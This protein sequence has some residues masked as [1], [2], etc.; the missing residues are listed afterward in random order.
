MRARTGNAHDYHRMSRMHFSPNRLLRVVLFIVIALAL[1]PAPIR[2][3]GPFEELFGGKK[4]QEPPKKKKKKPASTSTK[5]S[6]DDDDGDDQRLEHE[7]GPPADPGGDDTANQRSG[8][9][10]DA[11]TRVE[12]A[13]PASRTPVLLS[14]LRRDILRFFIGASIRL[15]LPGSLHRKLSFISTARI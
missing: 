11:M 9:G 14:M 10:A 6:S 8:G 2:A 5:K 13:A 3:A 12:N 7:R 15:F 1:P 4:K